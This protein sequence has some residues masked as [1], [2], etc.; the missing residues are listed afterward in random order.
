M[1]L[2]ILFLTTD[3]KTKLQRG[4]FPSTDTAAS[5]VGVAT[6]HAELIKACVLVFPPG[7]W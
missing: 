2:F 7:W 3:I 5:A 6:A 1:Y 4:I